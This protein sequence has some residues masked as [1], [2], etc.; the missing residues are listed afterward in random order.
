MTVM[1]V[2]VMVTLTVIMGGVVYVRIRKSKSYS[3]LI[4]EGEG[5]NIQEEGNTSVTPVSIVWNK[6][7]KTQQ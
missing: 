6:N 2:V 7:M 1:C 5:L 3:R 4:H